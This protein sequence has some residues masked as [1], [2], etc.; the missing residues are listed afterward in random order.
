MRKQNINDLEN[1]HKFLVFYVCKETV[2]SDKDI[3]KTRK[4]NLHKLTLK[5]KT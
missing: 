3:K 4:K 5:N 1:K 2:K